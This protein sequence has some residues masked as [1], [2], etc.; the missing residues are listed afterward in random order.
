MDLEHSEEITLYLEFGRYKEDAIAPSS[1]SY[2]NALNTVE[3]ER[4][5]FVSQGTQIKFSNPQLQRWFDKSLGDLALLIN[6]YDSGPYPCAGVPWF[7]VPFGRD[8]IIT[9]MEMLWARPEMAKG[10]LKFLSERQATEEI[11]EKEA[12]PGKII[13][14]TRQCEMANLGMVPYGMYY[15]GVDT[16]LLYIILAGEYLN[17]TEDRAFIEEIWPNI[18]AALQWIEDY[19]E[20]KNWPC[21]EDDGFIVYQM[22]G[23]A[24]LINQMWKDSVDAVYY[25]DGNL[26]V[27][28]PRAVCEVQGYAYAAWKTGQRMA[29]LFGDT[30]KASYYEAKAENLRQNFNEKFWDK[31]DGFYVLALDGDKEPCR[32]RASNM[33][34]LLFTGIVHQ[35]RVKKVVDMLMEK[36]FSS[37]FGI[38]TVPEG[39]VT[40]NPQSYHNGA[41]WPHDTAMIQKGM[42]ETGYTQ[43][44]SQ[45]FQDMFRAAEHY[46]WR[47]PELFSGFAREKDFGPTDY[48]RACA[49]QAWAAA[50]PFQG[51]QAMLGLKI[52]AEQHEVRIDP[53]NWPC[54][55]GTLTIENLQ[56]GDKTASFMLAFNE[57]HGGEA[58]LHVLSSTDEDVKIIVASKPQGLGSRLT[59]Y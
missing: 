11:L 48:P 26:D 41:I 14:E 13:H 43:E 15:G 58:V 7:A 4:K 5:E 10:V 12:E 39:E 47:L 42:G 3:Q 36:S 49:P 9:A 29:A 30:G 56:V 50:V 6:N 33:G 24:G 16:T 38:R 31:K 18:E 28:F 1:E 19:A 46:N 44:A 32:I 59:A 51:L 55:L 53:N 22:K 17:S 2:K 57:K 23:E 8:G 20:D 21:V 34:H 37:G 27:K 25:E 40:Y 52:N 45:V 54:E 35:E